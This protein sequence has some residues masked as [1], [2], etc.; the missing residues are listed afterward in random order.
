MVRETS[1]QGSHSYIF[2]CSLSVLPQIHA[3]VSDLCRFNVSSRHSEAVPA[4]RL[5]KRESVG[6]VLGG[7]CCPVMPSIV[8][9][10]PHYADFL[11]EIL[12]A[13]VCSALFDISLAAGSLEEC[14][15]I[16]YGFYLVVVDDGRQDVIGII[17]Q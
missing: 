14:I 1:S 17:N 16:K 11:A 4:A 8:S 3:L 6:F 15:G 2:V 10:Q 9:R 13:L 7:S 12:N 5:L